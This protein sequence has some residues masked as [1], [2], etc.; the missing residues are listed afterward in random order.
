MARDCVLFVALLGLLALVCAENTTPTPTAM[1]CPCAPLYRASE[2]CEGSRY[3]T[4]HVLPT[5]ESLK[6]RDPAPN[7]MELIVRRAGNGERLFFLA[8][9]DACEW[10][11]EDAYL[12]LASRGRVEYT[13]AG[14]QEACLALIAQAANNN[15]AHCERIGPEFS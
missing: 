13:K 11:G 1:R 4:C 15:G 6:R 8:D 14:Q 7:A 10:D 9:D 5:I 3:I 12:T 2:W